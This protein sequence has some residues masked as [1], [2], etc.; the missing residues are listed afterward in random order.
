MDTAGKG[1][2]H[3]LGRRLQFVVLNSGKNPA[4]FSACL[5]EMVQIPKHYF[6]ALAFCHMKHA[7][8][9]SIRHVKPH[10][11]CFLSLLGQKITFSNI[12]AFFY[13]RIKRGLMRFKNRR[14]ENGGTADA[15]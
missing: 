6:R 13:C 5:T 14:G 11:M 12:V 1:K 9:T 10:G 7:N 15:H 2:L 4:L 8:A 3:H